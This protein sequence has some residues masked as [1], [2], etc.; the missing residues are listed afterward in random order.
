MVARSLRNPAL[1]FGYISEDI[2]EIEFY[3]LE[4][5]NVIKKQDSDDT[6]FVM[7]GKVFSDNFESCESQDATVQ[8]EDFIKECNDL[9]W[10]VVREI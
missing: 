4:S 8:F 5:G 9:G 6:L 3:Y 7:N 1:T 10:R 2:M